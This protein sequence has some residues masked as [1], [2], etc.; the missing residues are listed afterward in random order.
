M[1][2]VVACVCPS[3]RT[4]RLC[5]S[6][7]KLYP[8]RT[9]DNSP[10]IWTEITKFA[11]NWHPCYHLVL[12]M[13]A[14]DLDLHGNFGHFDLEFHEIRFARAIICGGFE[15]ESSNLHQIW[16]WAFCHFDSEFLE[17]RSVHSIIYHGFGVD[18]PKLCQTCILGY[19]QLVLQKGSL[20][21]MTHFIGFNTD[22]GRLGVVTRP[23]LLLF[24]K[25]SIH[26][27]ISC[28]RIVCVEPAIETLNMPWFPLHISCHVPEPGP[29]RPNACNIGLTRHWDIM[30]CTVKYCYN[31][32]TILH[33][34][35]P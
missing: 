29:N 31:A 17:M 24:L 3:V 6:V 35:L 20:S 15:L 4:V 13:G 30:A 21:L 22:L 7:R 28:T 33:T 10:Q 25:D 9:I 11:P 14:I 23:N 19:S 26:V 1:D 32:V 2:I 12:K 18:S 8:V 5:L 34:T 27:H 16:L